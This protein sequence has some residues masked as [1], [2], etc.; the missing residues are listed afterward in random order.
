MS[1]NKSVFRHRHF[2]LNFRNIKNL[3][4]ETYNQWLDDKCLKMSAALSY[5]SIFSL[6]PL[7][8]I[9][10]AIAGFVFGR[11]AAQGEIVSQLSGLIGKDGAVMIE[12][13]IKSSSS[14]EAGIIATVISVVV[15]ILGSIGSFL[16][17]KESLNIIWGVELKPGKG[18]LNY[19]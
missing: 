11:E 19:F 15:L 13:M 1:K 17:L 10:I 8:I 12:T 14:S 4:F 2:R 16:E 7:I 9:V 18:I 5:Y 3:L 6:S